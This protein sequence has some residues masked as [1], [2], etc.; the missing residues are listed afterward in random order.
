MQLC[1]WQ[2]GRVQQLGSYR[3]SGQGECGKWRRKIYGYVQKSGEARSRPSNKVQ[4]SKR[5]DDV[6]GCN[7]AVVGVVSSFLPFSSTAG[8]QA[9]VVER[10]EEMSVSAGWKASQRVMNRSGGVCGK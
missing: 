9:N 8:R 3:G 10:V 5:F 1:E 7:S 2:R 4:S 6:F